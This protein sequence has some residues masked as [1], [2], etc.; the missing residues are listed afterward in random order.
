MRFLRV[1][2]VFVP[3]VLGAAICLLLPTNLMAQSTPVPLIGAIHSLGQKRF[4]EVQVIAATGLRTGQAFDLQ[5]IEAA[6]QKLGQSGAFD[7]VQ[8]KYRPDRGQMTVEFVVKEATKFH[9]CIYDNFVWTSTKEIEDFV[10]SE[11]PLFDGSAPE[12]GELPDEILSSLEHFLQQHGIT[13]RVERTQF[14]KSIGDPNWEHLYSVSGPAM[15]VESVAFEGVKTID[16][17][18]LE[19]EAKSLIGRNY[20]F[21]E[22]RRYA[23]AAFLPIYRERG[24]LRVNIESPTAK[25][26]ER[27]P[28]RNEIAIQ[29]VYSV[30]EGLAY[31]WEGS[32][33]SGNQAQSS[34]DLEALLGMKHGERAN[35]KKID[36]GL[37]AVQEAYGRKGYLEVRFL[38][39]TKYDEA[40][41][42]VEY[43]VAVREGAQYKMGEF[44]ISGLSAALSLKSK[45]RLKAGDVYDASYLKEFMKTQ[46]GP[47]L[48]G[49]GGRPP[50]IQTSIRP[51]RVSHTVAVSVQVQ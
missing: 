51:D 40:G 10:M 15:R 28:D 29:V 47:V 27:P 39:E 19:K 24:F 50:Q 30:E 48:P 42:K 8:F 5:A 11:V 9:R 13:S 14:A 44:A 33:W 41:Q 16:E 32:K 26:A 35:G 20:S 3:I 38:T 21:V 7:E 34:A 49:P 18:L 45:W 31:D 12:G 23:E 25:A 4:S 46:L 1:S 36:A 22:F 43:H 2:Q 6:T 37:E 17:K